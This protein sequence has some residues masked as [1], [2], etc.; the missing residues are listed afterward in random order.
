M[1]M[2]ARTRGVEE[3]ARRHP[4]LRLAPPF[5]CAFSRLG[6]QRW[7]AQDREGLG[8][9][10]DLSLKGARVMSPVSIKPGDQLAVSLRLPNQAVAMTVD[11]TVRWWN[12]HAFGLEFV[13]VSAL[14]ESRLKKFLSRNS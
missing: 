5:A 7:L 6:L 12:E 1:G 2:T 8:V 13:S 10:F 3:E 4:R 14:T 11:A 9:V